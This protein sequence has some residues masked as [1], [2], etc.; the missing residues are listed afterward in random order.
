MEKSNDQSTAEVMLQ[1][2][3][4]GFTTTMGAIHDENLTKQPPQYKKPGRKQAIPDH[5]VPVAK[6][7]LATGLGYRSVAR[8][9]RENYDLR[10]HWTRVRDLHK[11]KGV[12][13]RFTE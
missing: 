4:R 8:V 3:Y 2:P 1:G 10:L 12:Y 5:L 9:L 6:K 11:G 7:F 13:A